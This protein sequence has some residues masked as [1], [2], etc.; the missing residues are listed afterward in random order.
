MTTPPGWTPDGHA[1]HPWA[2]AHPTGS[3]PGLVPHGPGAALP[4]TAF[5][6]HRRR[7]RLLLIGGAV[8]A[9]GAMVAGV[10]THRGLT[11]GPDDTP[12]EA[13]ENFLTANQRYD[14][15]VAWEL[16]CHTEQLELGPLDRY[17]RTQDAAV[18]V[19]GPLND[20]LT[21]TVGDVRPNGRSSPQSYVVDVQLA[22][23][24]DTHRIEVLA[25]EEDDGF[26]A[27]GQL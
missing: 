23:A 3:D 27:C 7:T 16:L 5:H 26:R 14:W 19:V 17:I 11:S 9:V 2:L 24:G 6:P 1:A 10:L 25:V 21:I 22:Q 4:P 20:G 15:R 8:L 12:R 18:A 13:V